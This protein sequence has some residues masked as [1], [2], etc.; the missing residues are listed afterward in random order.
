MLDVLKVYRGTVWETYIEDKVT[1]T[2]SRSEYHD[3]DD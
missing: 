3:I 1:V 2:H